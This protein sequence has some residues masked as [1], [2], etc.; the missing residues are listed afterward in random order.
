MNEKKKILKI[1]ILS[2]KSIRFTQ[3][4]IKIMEI[5]ESY[6]QRLVNERKRKYICCSTTFIAQYHKKV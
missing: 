2:Y 4:F 5:F 3:Q 1:S 6:P